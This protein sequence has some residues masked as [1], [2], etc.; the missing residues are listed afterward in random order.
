MNLGLLGCGPATL[1]GSGTPASLTIVPVTPSYSRG[2]DSPARLAS[3]LGRTASLTTLPT[4]TPA[5]AFRARLIHVDSAAAEHHA[6]QPRYRT[7]RFRLIGHV[8]KGKS[9][10]LARVPVLDEVYP[11]D[12]SIFFELLSYGLLADAEIQVSN[13]DLLQSVSSRLRPAW[14]G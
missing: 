3:P 1:P 2:E 14:R 6:V 12:G 11:F 9:S 10:R 5:L 8:N 4:G 7:V 13:I